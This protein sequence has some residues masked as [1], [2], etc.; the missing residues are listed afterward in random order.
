[1][2]E[3]DFVGY[4]PDEEHAYFR[5]CIELGRVYF[6]P[7]LAA[8]QGRQVR[9][10][11]LQQLVASYARA[12]EHP[13]SVLEIG[14][15]AGGSAITIGNELRAHAKAGSRLFCLDPWQPYDDRTGSSY[16][17]GPMQAALSNG[18]AFQLFMHN[19]KAAGLSDLVVVLRGTSADIL[20]KLAPGTFDLVFV[21]GDHRYAAVK[22]DLML[23]IPLVRDGG[24]LCGDDLEKQFPDVDAAAC[25]GAER[26]DSIVDPKSGAT[27]HPGV[28][29]AVHELIGPVAEKAGFWAIRKVGEG[30]IPPE[31]ADVITADIPLHFRRA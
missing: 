18:S 7:V 5:R 25:I 14:S 21:D 15:W 17:D 11:I 13:L 3:F 26:D 6:G 9:H 12:A 10:Y 28:A 20:P 27:Y 8:F 2:T 4:T 30:F 22:S 19:V 1:M 16:I 31:L 24:I 29:R 23:S